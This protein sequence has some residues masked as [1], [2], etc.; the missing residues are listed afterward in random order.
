M[1]PT[2]VLIGGGVL[3]LAVATSLAATALL[4]APGPGVPSGASPT[5]SPA[6]LAF[7]KLDGPSRALA[8]SL[9]PGEVVSASLF[10]GNDD[11]LA[12][13]TARARKAGL[14]VEP[15]GGDEPQVTV[16][17]PHEAILELATLAII[18]ATRLHEDL[19]AMRPI[20]A[21]LQP[22]WSMPVP[23]RPYADGGL[24]IDP[25]RIVVPP[26][27]RAAM[28]AALAGLIETVDGRPY[29]NL[30]AEGS[31][32]EPITDCWVYLEGAG[33]KGSERVD[34]W[35]IHAS[36]ATGWLAMFDRGDPPVFRAVP[37][38]LGRE[39]ERIA[40]ADESA[41]DRIRDYERVEYIA[42]NPTA[43]GV[44]EVGYARTCGGGL[45]SAHVASL[46][47]GPVAEDGPC[48]EYLTITVDVGGGRV[49]AVR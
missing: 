6:P 40:R 19:R 7:S 48:D 16:T 49:V 8:E 15:A 14:T 3:I 23:G 26:D 21:S 10:S 11:R 43:P 44:I 30:T 36:V 46:D 27:L 1:R 34:H 41:L 38:W 33:V 2:R 20:A 28:L 24:P 39:A 32:A 17:G 31:C 45:G 5:D 25:G 37:R 12:E 29:G 35:P 18:G 4:I 47:R 22:G 42:W 13:I 9:L